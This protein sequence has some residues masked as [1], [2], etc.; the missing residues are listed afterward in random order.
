MNA[1]RFY[2][3]LVAVALGAV[4][5][6]FHKEFYKIDARFDKIDEEFEKVHRELKDL[7]KN[8]KQLLAKNKIK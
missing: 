4:G 3:G 2:F 5:F 7:S 8:V 1:G 6:Y